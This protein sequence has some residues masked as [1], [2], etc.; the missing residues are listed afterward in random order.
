MKGNFKTVS[1]III[2]V[3]MGLLVGIFIRYYNTP[4]KVSNTNYENKIINTNKPNTN[5]DT[6]IAT[7]NINSGDDSLISK[8]EEIEND[9]TIIKE[10]EKIDAEPEEKN[11]KQITTQEEN[12]QKKDDKTS[13][14]IISSD[15]TMTN[16]EKRQILTELDNTLMELLDVVDKVQTIDETRLITDESEVQK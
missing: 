11:D 3:L 10:N 5:V 9:S 16:K 13:G 14:V 2:I 4:I 15:G 12:I 1:T 7:K 8:S 6:P